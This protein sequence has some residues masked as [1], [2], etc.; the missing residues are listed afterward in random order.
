MKNS[1][2]ANWSPSE[3]GMILDSFDDDLIREQCSRC[4]YWDIMGNKVYSDISADWKAFKSK[5]YKEE[6]PAVYPADEDMV[7]ALT[8]LGY[9]NPSLRVRQEKIVRK[10]DKVSNRV[11]RKR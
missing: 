2:P 1:Y 9:R 7:V 3:F 4:L 6:I 8:M 10:V 5:Y 11:R